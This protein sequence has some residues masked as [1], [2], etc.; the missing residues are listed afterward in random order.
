MQLGWGGTPFFVWGAYFVPLGTSGTVGIKPFT[1]SLVRWFAPVSG[2]GVCFLGQRLESLI[3]VPLLGVGTHYLVVV[4]DQGAPQFSNL[5]DMELNLTAS[6][7]FQHLCETNKILQDVV[8]DSK[9]VW[10]LKICHII[11]LI[12][13]F[14]GSRRPRWMQLRSKE[15]TKWVCGL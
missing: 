5:S 9:Y 14:A 2:G 8:F 4:R 13:E 3:F 10:S 11:G 6:Q 12:F 15:P 7:I 1:L